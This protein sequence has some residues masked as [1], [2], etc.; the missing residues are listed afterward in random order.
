MRPVQAVGFKFAK[1]LVSELPYPLVTQSVIYICTKIVHLS[2][3]TNYYILRPHIWNSTPSTPSECSDSYRFALFVEK[4]LNILNIPGIPWSAP[5][6]GAW[7]LCSWLALRNV[8]QE[9]TRADQLRLR[10]VGTTKYNF[11]I[12]FLLSPEIIKSYQIKKLSRVHGE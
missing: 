6:V 4:Q 11:K 9:R 8:R 1:I 7:F 2:V 3:G 5:G 10:K 12:W